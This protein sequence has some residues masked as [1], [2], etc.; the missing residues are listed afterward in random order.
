MQLLY[1]NV[2]HRN[3]ETAGVRGWVDALNNGMT[4][5]EVLFGFSESRENIANVAPLIKNGINYTEWW[6]N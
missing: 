1:N 2:L 5:A 6:L 3:G 4:R